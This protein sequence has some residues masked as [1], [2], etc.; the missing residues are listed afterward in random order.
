V[1][2]PS[3]ILLLGTS[4]AAIRNAALETGGEIGHLETRR[5]AQLL[6]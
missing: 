3:E 6:R 2:P 4:L 1:E 5:L